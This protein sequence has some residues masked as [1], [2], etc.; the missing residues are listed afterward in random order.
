MNIIYVKYQANLH[1]T[2]LYKNKQ[3]K[4]PNS[5]AFNEFSFFI[6]KLIKW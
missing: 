4:K 1:F 2:L 6:G 3:I 5:Q